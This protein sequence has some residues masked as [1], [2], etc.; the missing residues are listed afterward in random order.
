MKI[1][2]RKLLVPL[3]GIAALLLASCVDVEQDIWINEDGSGRIVLKKGFS[4]EMTQMMDGLGQSLGEGLSEGLGDGVGEGVGDQVASAV[5]PFNL[6]EVEKKL[7]ANPNVSSVKLT[8]EKGE[9]FTYMVA[10]VELKDITKVHE[11][12]DLLADEG[13]MPGSEGEGEGGEAQAEPE[14]LFKLTKTD[15]GTYK[16][17]GSLKPPPSEG[18]DMAGMGAGMI[19]G[20]VGDAAFTY[21]I[22]AKPSKHNGTKEGD[23]IVWEIGLADLLGGKSLEIDGEFTP[24]KPGGGMA[25]WI[26]LAAVLA[27]AAVVFFVVRSQKPKVA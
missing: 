22:H 1:I 15:S 17:T 4:K 21:R 10:D 13:P 24:G 20:M 12:M 19:K 6:D 2:L 25:L 27:V 7:K 16:A 14:V 3:T 9:E 23:A 26:T 8:K 18:D 11:I 5:D